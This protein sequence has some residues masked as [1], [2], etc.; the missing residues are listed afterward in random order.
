MA[1]T[2]FS[3]KEGWARKRFQWEGE[4]GRGWDPSVKERNVLDLLR[5][6]STYS[7]AGCLFNYGVCLIP[8]SLYH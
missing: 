3:R 7:D 8:V 5:L 2:L 4:G 1:D 6:V